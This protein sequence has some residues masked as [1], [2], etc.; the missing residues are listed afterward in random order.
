MNALDTYA[1]LA[2]PTEYT[3]EIGAALVVT[4]RR[5]SGGRMAERW[6]PRRPAELTAEQ[7]ERYQDA[8][9]Q[10]RLVLRVAA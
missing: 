8:A 4:F 7:A 2:A 10:A 6:T 5:H 1:R 9:E 3:A